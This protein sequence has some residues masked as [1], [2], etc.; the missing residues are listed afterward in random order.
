MVVTGE[1]RPQMAAL[2]LTYG[3]AGEMAQVFGALAALAEDQVS[4]P[5]PTR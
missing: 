1:Y 5:T 3:G 4:F 2:R